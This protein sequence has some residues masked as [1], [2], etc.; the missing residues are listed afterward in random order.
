MS[1]CGWWNDSDG[2]NT[3]Q[4]NTF[5]ATNITCTGLG[6]KPTLLCE[7]TT[8]NLLRSGMARLLKCWLEDK[9]KME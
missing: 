1:V 3:Y 8:T 4:N 9:N 6:L 7:R 2:R 5:P